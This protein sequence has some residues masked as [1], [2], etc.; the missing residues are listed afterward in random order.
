MRRQL[1]PALLMLAVFTVI[2]GIG[3]PLLVTGVGQLMLSDK[4]NGSLVEQDGVAVGATVGLLD[5]PPQ[6]D[7]RSS[8]ITV[9]LP[10]GC[11]HSRVARPLEGL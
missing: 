1:L 6:M 10:S 4:A 2:T 5:G 9:R 3:Y 8:S 11:H 7:T